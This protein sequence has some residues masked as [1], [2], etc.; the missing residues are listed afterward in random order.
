M[1]QD[2]PMQG[3]F[4]G[5]SAGGGIADL[6]KAKKQELSW[7]LQAFNAA[8]NLKDSPLNPVGTDEFGRD[9]WN[10]IANVITEHLNKGLSTTDRG[11]IETV[12]GA[13][14]SAVNEIAGS[15]KGAAHHVSNATTAQEGMMQLLT[16]GEA[17][18]LGGAF[19]EPPAPSGGPYTSGSSG[20]PRPSS[21]DVQDQLALNFEGL[22]RQG[23]LSITDDPVAGLAE[24]GIPGYEN[25]P[26]D[27][28]A[29]RDLNMSRDIFDQTTNAQL[30]TL[31][32][33]DKLS[34]WDKW[35][36]FIQG[37]AAGAGQGQGMGAVAG[38]G[39]GGLKGLNDMRLQEREYVQKQAQ[40]STQLHQ[41]RARFL[42]FSGREK[43]EMERFRVTINNQEAKLIFNA[44][45]E[46]KR[47]LG[48]LV[49]DGTGRGWMVARKDEET[50]KIVTE[51]IVDWEAYAAEDMARMHKMN[52]T[53]EYFY[54]P[55]GNKM[56]FAKVYKDPVKQG[57]YEEMVRMALG[58]GMYFNL[59][60]DAALNREFDRRAQGD[61]DLKAKLLRETQLSPD[62]NWTAMKERLVLHELRGLEPAVFDAFVARVRAQDEQG[63]AALYAEQERLGAFS[64][65]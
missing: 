41:L 44:T 61:P 51:R 11:D 26:E 45:Q 7:W 25:L 1:P 18:P 34:K 5:S 17:S 12:K 59:Y 54:S 37:A 23:P 50:G 30:E 49:P 57:R 19:S 38:F 55:S 52:E 2:Y 42:Q 39:A 8:K 56:S 46:A 63:L 43:S 16:G 3:A 53:P 28:D 4:S 21:L 22:K 32:G 9:N 13:L 58:G 24:E 35:K 33:K 27:S 65:E 14:G 31:H 40:F 20:T 64:G 62:D 48:R 10:N 47:M 60:S 6:D 29:L 15:V 36:A